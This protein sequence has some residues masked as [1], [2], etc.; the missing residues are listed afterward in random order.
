ML[1]I[2]GI[3]PNVVYLLITVKFYDIDK[4]MVIDLL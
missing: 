1:G 2:F 4:T 3:K